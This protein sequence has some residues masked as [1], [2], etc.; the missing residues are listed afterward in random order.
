MVQARN[1]ALSAKVLIVRSKSSSG[2]QL[3]TDIP[4]A[5]AVRCLAGRQGLEPRYADPESAVLPLD[6]LPAKRVHTIL[7][8]GP[9]TLARHAD[10]DL[11]GCRSG[12]ALGSRL[13]MVAGEIS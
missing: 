6:D 9:E 13:G 11:F 12:G 3:A 1:R 4:I 2:Y 5:V 10:S 7:A 8:S